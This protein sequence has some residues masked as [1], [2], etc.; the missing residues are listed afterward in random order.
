MTIFKG[1]TYLLILLP[2]LLPLAA[3]AGYID[4]LNVLWVNLDAGQAVH[5]DKTVSTTVR[6]GCE[7]QERQVILYMRKR[8]SQITDDLVSKAF[9]EEDAGALARLKRALVDY[10]DEDIPGAKGDE[11]K[12]LDGIIVYSSKPSPRLISL[13]TP[14]NYKKKVSYA[15]VA[16]P[17]DAKSFSDLFCVSL[18]PLTRRP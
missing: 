9:I 17:F 8:P 12:G 13:T 7:G 11:Q 5:I 1:N 18:P 4:Q 14:R 3:Q 16:S 6:Q 10:R 2:L 15:E